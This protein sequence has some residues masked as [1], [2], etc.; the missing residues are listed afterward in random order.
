MGYFDKIWNLPSKITLVRSVPGGS[1]KRNSRQRRI[2]STS[3]WCHKK[4]KK[5]RRKQPSKS[6]AYSKGT[7]MFT[8]EA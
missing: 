1:A 5:E 8:D 6:K 3:S 7:E 4:R 2:I